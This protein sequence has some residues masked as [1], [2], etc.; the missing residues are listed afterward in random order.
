VQEGIVTGYADGTFRPDAYI[1]RAEMAVMIARALGMAVGA[2]IRTAFADDQE[3]PTWAK[4]A[5]E[6]LRQQGIIQG[7]E[8]NRFSPRDTATRAEAAVMLLRMMEYGD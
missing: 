3:I 2:E 6:A 5:V 4:G 1:T 8:G 7:R